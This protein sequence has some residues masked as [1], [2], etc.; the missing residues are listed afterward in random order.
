VNQLLLSLV[1]ALIG[2]I[3]I[4]FLTLFL[5][6]RSEPVNLF[7]YTILIN[8]VTNPLMNYG[9]IFLDIPLL[10]L[11][12]GVVLTEMI[13][14]WLLFCVNLRYACICSLCANGVSVIAGFFWM[15]LQ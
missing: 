8:G 6:I 11:E 15:A 3:L 2:T 7:I 14:I 12:T 10:A 1:S 4:E 13:L 9:L 5:L